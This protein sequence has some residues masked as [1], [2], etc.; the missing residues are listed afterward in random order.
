MFFLF[1]NRIGCLASLAISA[2]VSLLLLVAMG[3]V[4][5]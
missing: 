1:S 4:S 2:L 5:L 3:I